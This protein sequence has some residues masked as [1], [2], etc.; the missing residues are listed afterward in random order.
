MTIIRKLGLVAIAGLLLIGAFAVPTFSAIAQDVSSAV[1]TSI[2]PDSVVVV[3][4]D[5]V[6]EGKDWI[7]VIR[8]LAMAVASLLTVVIGGFA[9]PF[10][11]KWFGQ[12]TAEELR[13]VLHSAG[14]TAAGMV[15]AK[16]E[17]PIS[18]VKFDVHNKQ[19]AEAIDWV[20]QKGASDAVD[21]FKLSTDDIGNLILGKL[22]QLQA[23]GST[24]TLPS[25]TEQVPPK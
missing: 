18:N 22:G 10:L 5:T 11:V 24:Q 12:K 8:D 4:A 23:A 20:R 25:P 14:Q 15:V 17:G 1:V 16:M 9:T 21:K 2:P 6:I 13:K 7:D 3:P 19:L